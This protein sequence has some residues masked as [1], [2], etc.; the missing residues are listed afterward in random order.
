MTRPPD[1]VRLALRVTP[2]GGRDVIEGVRDGM[3]RVRVA[4][5]PVD[6]GANE[7]V[8]RL[9]AEALGVPRTSVRLVTGAGARLKTVAV[10][11]ITRLAVEARWP[12]LGV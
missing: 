11:G 9:V 2:R 10:S 5:A 8:I 4:A 1:E 6:G 7:A 12:G 3:L